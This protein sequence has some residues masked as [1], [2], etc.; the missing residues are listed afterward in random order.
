M[1]MSIALCALLILALIASCACADQVGAP[2]VPPPG[3]IEPTARLQYHT[4]FEEGFPGRNAG[5]INQT[6]VG[7]PGWPVTAIGHQMRLR[8]SEFDLRFRVVDG[9]SEKRLYTLPGFKQ[10]S[11]GGWLP[12]AITEFDHNGV[13]YRVGYIVAPNDPQPVDLISIRLENTTKDAK[14]GALRVLFDGAPTVKL[15]NGVISD[16]GKPLAALVGEPSKAGQIWRDSGIVDPRATAAGVWFPAHRNGFYGTPIHYKIKMN[17]PFVPPYQGGTKGGGE[18]ALVT[19][20]FHGTPPISGFPPSTW[21][22]PNREVIVQVEGGGEPRKLLVDKQTVLEFDGSDTDG[23]GYM[24]IKVRATP[25]SRQPAI[26][27]DIFLFAPGSIPPGMIPGGIDH[28]KLFA[29]QLDDIAIKHII[30]GYDRPAQVELTQE[31]MDPTVAALQLDYAPDLAPG[32]KRDYEI[33]LPAIDKPELQCYGNPYHPYDTG[34]S[35]LD[36]RDNRHP[37]N[38]TPYGA[39]VPPGVDP[40]DYAAFGPKDRSVWNAQLDAAKKISFDEGLKRVKD[41]WDKRLAGAIRFD[42][43]EPSIVDTY[44]HQLAMLTLHRLEF[45][46][47]PYAVMMGGPFFYWD[48]CY[49]DAAYESVALDISGLHDLARL[50]MN[51]YLTPKSSIPPGMIP[52]I[53]PGKIPSIPPGKIPS[54]PPGMIPG[55]IE[56]PRSRWTIGQ[57]DDKDHD[58]LFMTREGQWDAQGQ[59][60]WAI[61][62]H[63]MLTGDRKWLESNYSSIR[64]A[65]EWIIRE[66]DK[67]KKRLGDPNSA[68][69]GLLPEGLMEGAPWG[70]ALYF[71]GW[72]ALGLEHVSELARVSGRPDDEKRYSSEA[73]ELRKALRR[74]AAMS[75]QR[76]GYFAGAVPVCPENPADLAAWAMSALVHSDKVLSPHDPLID[77]SWKFRE[78]AASQTGGLMDWPY[79]NTDWALGYI[80]R[81]EPDRCTQ[82]FYTYLSLASGTMDWGEWYNLNKTF[83]EFTPPKVAP[84]ADSDMPHSESC[85]NFVYLFRSMMLS[86]VGSDLSIAPAA[87]RKWLAPGQHFGVENA[88]SHFG[89]VDYRISADATGRQLRAEITL[90]GNSP[91]SRVLVSFRTPQGLGVASAKIDGKPTEAFVGDCVVVARPGKRVVVEVEVRT[92]R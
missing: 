22:V 88:P 66:I 36:A 12:G 55:G 83:D 38:K 5:P 69:Y 57:W 92:G 35:W 62:E 67:E 26:L 61:F 82:L 10:T 70:H 16:R 37:E 84:E 13:H 80:D 15:E 14:K 51:A 32:E 34:Q 2:L 64:R 58:G 30:C 9:D 89:N 6:S 8:Y 4:S 23:D 31:G 86:E 75:F 74:A 48:F 41:Y 46:E 17:P 18:K 91:P 47:H 44:K 72:A 78:N 27:G 7:V 68:A 56:M 77:A 79:I 73:E 24:D 43:C 28:D 85:S 81:G 50:Q 45:G 87:P 20:C 52:S 21:P 42:I 25:E 90:A 54:I 59:S 49:R 29:R 3:P 11:P 76:K 33:R 63:A 19:L 60:L 1:E 65:A 40:A 53:P 39:D 71:N